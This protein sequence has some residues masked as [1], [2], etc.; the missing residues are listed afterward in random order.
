MRAGHPDL[1]YAYVDGKLCKH[2]NKLGMI[3]R[4]HVWQDVSARRTIGELGPT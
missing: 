2:E 3:S 1:R 4:D